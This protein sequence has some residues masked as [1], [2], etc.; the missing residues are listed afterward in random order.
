[1]EATI[2]RITTDAFDA[3]D[4]VPA[5]QVV[6]LV[7]RVSLPIPVAVIAELLGMGEQDMADVRRWSDAT[8]EIT[9]NPTEEVD[10]GCDRVHAVPRRSR[11]AALRVTWRRL[12]FAARR[13]RGSATC[14]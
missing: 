4:D 11:A 10:R 6:D 8:I 2:R 12:A 14:R 9:D 13:R 1:M 5:G 3:L 7:Q